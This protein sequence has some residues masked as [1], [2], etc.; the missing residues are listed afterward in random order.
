PLL[1]T[2][3]KDAGLIDHLGYRDEF[4]AALKEKFHDAPHLTLSR[5]IEA[6]PPQS[7]P[8]PTKTVAI[9]TASGEISRGGAEESPLSQEE[10][11]KSDIPAKAIRDAAA[12][13]D[14]SAIVI[15]VD[16]PGGDYVASDTIWR[17]IAKAKDKKK[18]IIVSM[19]NTAASGGY[20]ISMN[21]D[22]VFA[23]P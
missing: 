13:K 7:Q 18:P 4:E 2:E 1:A 23:E 17:A 3:A 10:G 19:G 6:D 9:V 20:F 21:A 22:H 14:V 15:R 5:Y 12:N 16:S 8:Q 11:I